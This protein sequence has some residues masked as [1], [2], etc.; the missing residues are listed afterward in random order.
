MG[1]TTYRTIVVNSLY[2]KQGE[3]P[4]ASAITPGNLIERTSAGK[5]QPHSTAGGNAQ[6]MFAREDDSQLSATDGVTIDT[7]YD[8]NDRCHWIIALPGDE[9]LAS[10]SDD[11]SAAGGNIAIGDP[12]TSDG[13][14]ALKK[15]SAK[16]PESDSATDTLYTGDIVAYALEAVDMSGSDDSSAIGY[17]YRILVEI[18]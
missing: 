12:L 6:R 10:V 3:T 13:S 4:A 9:I 8:S 14:G 18:A 1:A 16:T 15:W 17:P 7:A 5:V 2:G 11:S